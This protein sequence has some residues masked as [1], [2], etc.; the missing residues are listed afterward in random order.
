MQREILAEIEGY[1]KV[2][3][4][5]RA[6]VENCR[7]TLPTDVSWPVVQLGEV[8]CEKPKNGYSGEPVDHPTDIRVLT[9]TATTSGKLNSS[10]YKFLDEDIALDAQSRCRKGDIY[11]QRGNT[12]G[13][14]GTAALFDIYDSNY[15]YPDLMIRVRAEETKI[16]SRYLLAVLQSP[17]VRAS[18][19]SNAVGSAGSMPKIN[20]GIVERV[21]V[22]LPPLEEQEQIV[23]ELEAERALVDDNRDLI[24]RFEG[25]IRATLNRIWISGSV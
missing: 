20:Q 5:A 13:L 19:T 7:S 24:A 11:L 9:L 3:D 4:G 12:A 8:I 21:P 25:K 10:K 6:V 23:A 2:I 15:I 14:V 16:L 1:Q 17:P 18:L 22:P